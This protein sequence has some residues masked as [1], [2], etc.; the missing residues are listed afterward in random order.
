VVLAEKVGSSARQQPL[1]DII[2]PY[3][4]NPIASNLELSFAPRR[5]ANE[6]DGSVGVA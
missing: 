3:P 1:V 4:D 5:E 6:R 2:I